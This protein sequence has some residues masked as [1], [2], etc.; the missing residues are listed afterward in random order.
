MNTLRWNCT[1]KGCFNKILR[2]KI[3]MFGDCFP[4]GINF[5]DV[6]G[7]VEISGAFCLLEWK[8]GDMPIPAAQRFAYLNFT[9]LSPR[10]I[11]FVAW[12]DAATMA[13]Q[14]FLIVSGGV[15]GTRR[16]ATL[17]ELKQRIRAWADGVMQS[18][19]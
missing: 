18:A 12:G 17:D 3:E 11:V 6:D 16:P 10:N 5:G 19:A 2:P 14:N 15:I 1:I 8:S 4:R 9:K 7:M 13:V